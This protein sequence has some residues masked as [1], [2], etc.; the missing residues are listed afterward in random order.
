MTL[1]EYIQMSQRAG[2]KV[3]IRSLAREIPCDPSYVAKI[4][5]DEKFPS[6]LMARRIE[7]V[8]NGLVPKTNWYPQDE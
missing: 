8:T 5:R 4:A 6:Y 3:S 2:K 1:K 7:N